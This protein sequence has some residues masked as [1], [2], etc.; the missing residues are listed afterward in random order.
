MMTRYWLQFLPAHPYRFVLGSG[1][2]IQFGFD[3]VILGL[4]PLGQ[5][6]ERQAFIA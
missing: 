6:K 4:D 3:K 1:Q 5:W 2:H